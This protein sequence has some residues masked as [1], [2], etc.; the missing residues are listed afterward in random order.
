MM[1]RW[2]AVLLCTMLLVGVCLPAQADISTLEASLSRWMAARTSVRFSAVM[3]VKELN[4]FTEDTL[5]MLNALLG[6]VQVNASIEQD[7]EATATYAQIALDGTALLDWNERT[8]TD[9]TTLETSLLPN[10][11]LQSAVGSPMDILSAVQLGDAVAQAKAAEAEAAA[12]GDASDATVTD[13]AA[14]PEEAEAKDAFDLLNAV[15]ELQ[16]CYQ[17][18]TDGI[19]PFAEE[20]TASYKIKNIGSGKWSRVARL[21]TEQSESLLTELRAVLACG[22]DD[23]HRA[24]IDQMTFQ[25]GF[26]VA[27]YRNADQQDICVYMKGNVIYPDGSKRKLAFQW[28]FTSNGLKRVDTYKYELT[29]TSGATDSRIIA[30]SGTQESRSDAFSINDK[31]ETTLKRGKTT[32]KCTT[33]IDLSGKGAQDEP[34]T[35]AG[36]LSRVAA[37]TQN[38]DTTTQTET[39]GVDLLMTP[40]ADDTTLS[41]SMGYQKKLDKTVETDLE[42]TLAETVPQAFTEASGE[43][44][45][46][47]VIGGQTGPVEITISNQDEEATAT[48]ETAAADPT[49]EPSATSDAA[50]ETA[51]EPS[52]LELIDETVV[53]AATQDGADTAADASA[54]LVGTAPAGLQTFTTPATATTVDLDS[55]DAATLQALMQEAAQTLAGKMLVALGSLSGDDLAWLK[56][57]MTD[58]DWAAFEALLGEL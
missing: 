29:K 40:D 1:K 18:L 10:R 44:G 31:T 51:S 48:P 33:K 5:T 12:E 17:A 4:P 55:A 22:M 13:D 53:T 41:G 45:L 27:L 24:E 39:I 42:W 52:S 26:V 15:E 3:Q 36:E 46:Y 32:D 16:A 8:Q 54:Y 6:H 47:R 38:G 20:K 19:Q 9:L 37:L 21:T 2:V 28:A 7:G 35:C 57:G 11:T 43:N 23:A 34:M 58:T 14:E 50:A 56:D 25:K 49:A 30:A